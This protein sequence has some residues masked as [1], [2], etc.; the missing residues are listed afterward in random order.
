MYQQFVQTRSEAQPDRSSELT[1]SNFHNVSVE[2]PL[3]RVH[4]TF[5]SFDVEI[6]QRTTSEA[7]N[8]ARRSSSTLALEHPLLPGH[9]PN[10]VLHYGLIFFFAAGVLNTP[11]K[12]Q[13]TAKVKRQTRTTRERAPVQPPSDHLQQ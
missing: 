7:R 3:E 4:G 2:H 8:T 6:L 13:T 11:Y 9:Q 5:E 10:D 1:E 12:L